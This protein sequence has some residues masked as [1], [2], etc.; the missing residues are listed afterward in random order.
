MQ[1]GDTLSK[2]AAEY[3]VSLAALMRVN[4]MT[5]RDRH[6]RRAGDPATDRRR[7]GPG[8]G[9][10]RA[11]G[12]GTRGACAR[13]RLPRPLP[14]PQRAPK[15]C[16][17]CAAG[18]AS[19]ESQPGSAS[20]RQQLIA[21]NDIRDRNLIQVGQ[22]LIIPNATGRAV[23][24]AAATTPSPAVESPVAPPLESPAAV[25]AEPAAAADLTAAL[26]PAVL[27]NGEPAPVEADDAAEDVADVNALATEQ[28][29]L[30]ADPSDYSVS[31]A[32]EISVQALETLG[33]YAD[34]LEH[35]D[36]A[37]A[38]SEL[39]CRSARL[40]CWARR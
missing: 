11:R 40:W 6:P 5:N 4:G 13:R 2:I 14:S 9:D 22:Q 28:D 1:R 7:D 8:G 30:A 31:A 39:A 35:T 19:S 23:A 37:V 16:T 3:R 20:I 26:A 33:H 18:T 24:V 10:A 17:S 29:V 32:N 38:R 36:A 21:A 27:A 15:A 34:W 12:G 25:A